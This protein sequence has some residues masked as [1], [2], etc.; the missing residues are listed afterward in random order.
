MITHL[1]LRNAR[2]QAIIDTLDKGGRAT[3]KM[4]D[5][6]TLLAKVPLSHPCGKVQNGSLV[7]GPFGE[8]YG[9][10]MG[11]ADWARF[12][13]GKGEPVMD[14]SVGVEDADIVMTGTTAISINQPVEIEHAVFTEPGA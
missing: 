12:E 11:S 10:A 13:N 1:V 6:K 3:L 4:Y 14:V 9:L 2:L 8:A 7:L 5:G